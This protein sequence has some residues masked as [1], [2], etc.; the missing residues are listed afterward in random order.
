VLFL[1]EYDRHNGVLISV[2]EYP[3]DH[4]EAAASDRLALE[5][6]LLKSGARHEVV[7]LEAASKEHLMSTHRRYFEGIEGLVD[8]G[9]SKMQPG[10]KQRSEKRAG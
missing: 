7:L 10:N 1:L 2:N 6:E 8:F 5:I 9:E 3:S 4:Q